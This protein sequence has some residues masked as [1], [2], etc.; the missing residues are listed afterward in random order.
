MKGV[1]LTATGEILATPTPAEL[2]NLFND[3]PK[4]GLNFVN[5]KAR[6]L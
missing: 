3:S 6:R 4:V 5:L 2:A 1:V